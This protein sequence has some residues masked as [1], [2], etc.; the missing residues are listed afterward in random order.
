MKHFF[1]L[2]VFGLAAFTF[3]PAQADHIDL[4]KSYYDDT[5]NE[6]GTASWYGPGFHGRLTA[7]GQ[8]YNQFGLTAAHKSLKFGQVLHITNSD[9]GKSTYV[10]INDRGPYIGDR[11]IDLSEAAMK[12]LDGMKS[13]VID[14][15][16]VSVTDRQGVPLDPEL[17]FFVSCSVDTSLDEAMK[18]LDKLHKIG[19]FD[20]HL[21][22]LED[23]YLVGLGP[24]EDF[25][26]AQNELIDHITVFP[27]ATIELYKKDIK[28]LK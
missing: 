6:E 26:S 7:N 25:A 23:G 9:N 1:S 18:S 27:L 8:R 20:V 19:I 5:F 22:P 4:S 21:F 3:Q 15:H 28:F 12:R 17:S 10:Q 24:F 2:L 16:A 11:I 14:M 13:G